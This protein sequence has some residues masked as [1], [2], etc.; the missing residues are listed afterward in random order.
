MGA[1][2]SAPAL[3]ASP[4][5]PSREKE[6]RRRS[7]IL[8]MRRRRR[9]APVGDPSVPR[10]LPALVTMLPLV[11]KIARWYESHWGLPAAWEHADLTQEGVVA[12][13]KASQRFD[14]NR[15]CS[16]ATYAAYAVRG[17]LFRALTERWTT[18]NSEAPPP[19]E[20]L[21]GPWLPPER[22]VYF[23]EVLD[24]VTNELSLAEQALIFGD[25]DGEPI[26]AMAAPLGLTVS[27]AFRWHRRAVKKVRVAL[28]DG[29]GPATCD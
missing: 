14:P 12:L 9:S 5:A 7:T 28:G 15:N 1:V 24:A 19:D 17:A 23:R 27:S 8:P 26:S 11:E 3:P 25:A 6:R 16:F 20:N 4:L 10:P 2:P 18:L 13:V 29:V 21:K 22:A